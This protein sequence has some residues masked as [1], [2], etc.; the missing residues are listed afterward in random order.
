MSA[1]DLFNASRDGNLSRVR[2]LLQNGV[3]PNAY[4]DQ[5]GRSPLWDASWKGH[6]QIVRDLLNAGAIVDAAHN[7]GRTPLRVAAYNG[8]LD[9][10]K[11]L[12]HAGAD[13]ELKAN[14]GKT[15]LDLAKVN[16]RQ[17]TVDFLTKFAKVSNDPKSD[18]LTPLAKLWRAALDGSMTEQDVF[19]FLSN[20]NINSIQ[21]LI[22][23]HKILLLADRANVVTLDYLKSFQDNPNYLATN[24]YL[25][26]RH[27]IL[28][29]DDYERIICK[30]VLRHA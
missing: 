16:R 29:L 26:L 14:D 3:D 15:A 24:I 20:P 18:E 7:D 13:L 22:I 2:E 10:V 5:F 17:P 21:M 30:Y 6:A 1:L 25:L 4:K 19:L 8:H 9:V 28:G 12:L 23:A 11:V 27:F